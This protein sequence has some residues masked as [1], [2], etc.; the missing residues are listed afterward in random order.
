[1]G[2]MT[3][4]MGGRMDRWV[5]VQIGIVNFERSNEQFLYLWIVCYAVLRLPQLVSRSKESRV[6]DANVI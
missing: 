1:M 4:W 5:A 3:D 6:A 2:C